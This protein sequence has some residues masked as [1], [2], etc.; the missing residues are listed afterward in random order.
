[1]SNESNRTRP[2]SG[3][4]MRSS[5]AVLLLLASAILLYDST[6]YALLP[7]DP[8]SGRIRGCYTLVDLTVGATMPTR[9]ARPLELLLGVSCLAIIF[10]V[11]R[12]RISA[13]ASPNQRA[14][15]Q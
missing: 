6:P 13:G 14:V 3:F 12:K 5:V 15:E 1:V 8:S 10:P 4:L 11:L 9:W 7:S 2:W